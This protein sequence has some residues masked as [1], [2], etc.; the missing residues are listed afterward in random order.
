[1]SLSRGRKVRRSNFPV[2][3]ETR[4]GCAVVFSGVPLS[5]GCWKALALCRLCLSPR[6]DP[7]A[8]LGFGGLNIVLE[9]SDSG[10][11]VNRCFGEPSWL[12]SIASHTKIHA[13][14]CFFSVL[15]MAMA[16]VLYVFDHSVFGA[17]EVCHEAFAL[18]RHHL[19]A[20]Q[21]SQDLGYFLCLLGWFGGFPRATV[22]PTKWASR[23][24]A[25]DQHWLGIDLRAHRVYSQH[26]EAF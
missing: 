14:F 21:N 9:L 26:R 10:Y 20:F 23:Q 3:F 22:C 12:T 25:A 5:Q 17:D 11:S 2:P 6:V 18:Y 7:W 1:M 19:E 24:F 16:I 8:K 4:Y 15:I 13:V